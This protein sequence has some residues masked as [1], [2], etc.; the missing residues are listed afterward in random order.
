M[1]VGIAKI[2][3]AS[4]APV[5]DLHVL[6]CPRPA[7][8]DNAIGLN[9]ANNSIEFRLTHLE[10]IVMRFEVARLVKIEGPKVALMR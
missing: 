5:V 1:A 10:G 7:A 4:A 2:H 6:E 9:P 3:A 8:I